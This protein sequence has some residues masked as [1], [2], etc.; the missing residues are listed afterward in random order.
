MVNCLK[1]N[2][3]RWYKNCIVE[4]GEYF[5]FENSGSNEWGLICNAPLPDDLKSGALVTLIT[6]TDSSNE[7][8]GTA[9]LIISLTQTDAPKFTRSYYQADYVIDENEIATIA[10]QNAI[11]IENKNQENVKIT[12]TA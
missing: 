5:Q 11:R 9:L 1:I 6:A 4:Y 3:F 12:P 7:L 2:S 8:T 10:L